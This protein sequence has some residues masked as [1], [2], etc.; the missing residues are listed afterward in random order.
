[1]NRRTLYLVDLTAYDRNTGATRVL[2]YANGQG[3]V[4][5]PADTPANTYYDA[6]IKQPVNVSR[7]AFSRGATTGRSRLG[8]GDLILLNGDG[9]L[10]FILD[11][12]LDGRN[13]TVWRTEVENP[14]YPT[15]FRQ[16]VVGTM[17]QPEFT[18]NVVTIKLRDRQVE[19]SVPLQTTKYAGT[20]ALPNGL[21]GVATDLKG[22]PKPV[23][24][25]YVVNIAPPSVNTSKLIY[26]VNDGA[27]ASVD[28]VYDRG[29]ALTKGADY[30]SE[31]DMLATAPA[32]ANF[33]VWPTGGYFR[34]GTSPSG[35]VT[36]DVTQGASAGERT[37]GQIYGQLIQRARLAN[38]WGEPL[39][40]ATRA[41]DAGDIRVSDTGLFRITSGDVSTT[42]INALDTANSSVLGFWT[43]EETTIADVCDQ[44]AQTV[45][46][47]WGVD[48][49][50]VFRIQRFEAP[51]AAAVAT[52]T[53][54]DLLKQLE[55]LPTT[56]EGRG[57]PIYRQL[58][59]WGRFYVTQVADV[60]SSVTDARKGQLANEWREAVATDASIQERHLLSPEVAEDSLFTT[61]AAALAEAQRR[62]ALRTPRRDRFELRVPLTDETD[63]I[64]LGHVVN[65]HHSRYGL[66][67]LGG[68]EGKP[69]VVIGVEPDAMAQALTLNVWGSSTGRENRVTDLEA[70]RVT[71]TGAYRS[72]RAE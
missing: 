39:G 30:A 13:V 37:A 44:V 56:D 1:M 58:V 38:Q 43:D 26:Q 47:W 61:E 72:T 52:F 66:T 35:L 10:D 71:D 45:G 16:V 64:D 11:L 8:Y 27:V 51:T 17:E 29:V 20:N 50:G 15:D 65:I 32:A 22:K 63:D 69:F 3:Y 48:R 4:T 46:A 42:D 34:L 49:E 59:R 18:G 40:Q 5:G 7:D 70:Y 62:L 31:A 68:E 9:A 19:L 60:A 12:A 55:R 28:A 2:R 21:E 24:Y 57:I 67:V 25:G 33:R 6:R 41:T 23:C 14:R 53:A 36:A 54:D